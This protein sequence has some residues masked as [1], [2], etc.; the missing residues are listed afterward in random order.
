MVRQYNKVPG[1]IRGTRDRSDPDE[2]MRVYL[3]DYMRERH[4]RRRNAFIESRGGRCE[5][6]DS[7]EN[8]EVDHRDQREKSFNISFA[9]TAETKLQAELEKCQVLCRECHKAKTA[10]E[11]KIKEL[12]FK[13][14]RALH[15]W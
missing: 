10:S 14:W 12:S 9:S 3:R 8:L 2:Y 1:Y 7:T 15:A 13:C 11:N 6:C 5:A 4:H